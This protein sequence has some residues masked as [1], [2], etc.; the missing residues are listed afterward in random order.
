MGHLWCKDKDLGLIHDPDK[1]LLPILLGK[2]PCAPICVYVADTGP[3]CLSRFAV[4]DLSDIA[5]RKAIA[6]MNSGYVG[7]FI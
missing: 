2:N 1:L 5:T 7:V 4:K 6:A 3:S